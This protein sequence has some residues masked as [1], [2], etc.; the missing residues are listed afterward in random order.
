MA[1]T[2]VTALPVLS[3]TSG[4]DPKRVYQGHGNIFVNQLLYHSIIR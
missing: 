4:L 2:G 3:G 1:I